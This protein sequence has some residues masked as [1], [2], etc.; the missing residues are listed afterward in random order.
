MQFVPFNN[1]EKFPIVGLG[2]WKVSTYIVADFP[3]S[4]IVV[5]INN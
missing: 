5:N 4:D 3:N 2:T 1:G